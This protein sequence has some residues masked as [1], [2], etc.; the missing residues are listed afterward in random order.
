M[1][2]NLKNWFFIFTLPNNK[3][4]SDINIRIEKND[5]MNNWKNLNLQ[6]YLIYFVVF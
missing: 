2:K 3:I 1:K 6:C 4:L 5:K